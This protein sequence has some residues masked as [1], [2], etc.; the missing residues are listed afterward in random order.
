MPSHAGDQRGHTGDDRQDDAPGDDRSDDRRVRA[1]WCP[2]R[3]EPLVYTFVGSADP[4]Y[5][6][7][8]M[9][10]VWY[11]VDPLNEALQKVSLELKRSVGDMTMEIARLNA[12]RLTRVN[13]IVFVPGGAADDASAGFKALMRDIA[14]E[15]GGQFL[16]VSEDELK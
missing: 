16:R 1:R 6:S 13:T 4:E 11:N 9:P 8:L 2:V 5:Q 3:S 12:G 7:V 15:N 14:R 10:V